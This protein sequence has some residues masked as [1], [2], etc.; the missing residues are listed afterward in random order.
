MGAG[1]LSLGLRVRVAVGRD[2]LDRAL[3]GGA[4][5]AASVQ[6]AFPALRLSASA[7]E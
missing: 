2:A 5:P 3:A 7:T 1:L 4:D 6:L